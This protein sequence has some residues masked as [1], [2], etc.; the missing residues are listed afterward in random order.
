VRKIDAIPRDQFMNA[1]PEEIIDHVLSAM[2][3]EPLVIYEDRAEMDQRETK[4]DV[5]ELAGQKSVR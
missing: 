5:S 3:V 1:Q 4:I 2:T